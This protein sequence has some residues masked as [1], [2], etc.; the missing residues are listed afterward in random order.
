MPAPLTFALPKGRLL[1]PALHLLTAMGIKG[2]D[3]DTRRLLLSDESR[4][5]RVIFLKPA[6][7]PT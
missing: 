7:I 4:D 3:V 6:D 2:L 1:D 5:L